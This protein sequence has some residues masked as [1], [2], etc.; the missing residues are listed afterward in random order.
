MVGVHLVGGLAGTILIGFFASASTP[1]GVDGLFYGGGLDQLWRQIVGAAAVFVTSFVATYLIGMALRATMG[2][3]VDR[4]AEL[5]GVD[6]TE[7]AETAYELV[8]S[9]GTRALG[10]IHRTPAAH[11]PE[12]A[13]S[14]G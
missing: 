2:F 14:E 5:E 7:H 6:L 1:A 12:P 4:D 9:R 3:R 10:A 8:G 11:R 13:H